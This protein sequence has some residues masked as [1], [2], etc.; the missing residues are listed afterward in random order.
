MLLSNEDTKKEGVLDF[1]SFQDRKTQ[2]E[3]ESENRNRVLIF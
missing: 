2:E 3:K 1:T